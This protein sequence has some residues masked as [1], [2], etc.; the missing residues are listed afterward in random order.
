ML[1][2]TVLH[3]N[4]IVITNAISSEDVTNVSRNRFYLET[5][6]AAAS[7][8]LRT[9]YFPIAQADMQSATCE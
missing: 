1:V 7:K 5:I 3:R 2:S 9:M 8:Q 6:A 4:K